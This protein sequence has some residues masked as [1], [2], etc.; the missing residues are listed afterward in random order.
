[1]RRFDNLR[2]G[3]KLAFLVFVVIA[4][5]AGAGT[6]V[7][8]VMRGELLD[9]RLQQ[10]RAITE[11]TRGIA[12]GLQR[13]EAAG[14]L[15]HDEALRLFAVNA[16]SMTYGSQGYVFAYMMDGTAVA[17]PDVSQLGTNRLD[18]LI[19]GRPVIH[20]I[21]DAVLARGEAVIWYDFP[22][23]GGGSAIPKV[24]VATAFAPWGIFFGTGAYV[25]DL[26][27]QFW[28][29]VKL[30]AAGLGVFLI[31]V[32][33]IAWLI[34]KRITSP[35]ARLTSR[36][37]QLSRG[38]LEIDITDA[39]R[40]DE[41]GKMA[42]AMLLFRESALRSRALEREQAD[43]NARRA[44]EDD[45]VRQQ[46]EAAAA[47]AA[48]RLVVGSIGKGLEALSAGDL[49]FRLAEAL[50]GDYEKLRTDYNATMA[51]LTEVMQ[52]L[53]GV[54]S[55][56][57]TS[58][59]EV[60]QG[61]DDLCRRTENHASSFEETAAALDQLTATVRKTV[62]GSMHVSLVVSKTKADAALSGKVVE[63]A[64]QA[65]GGIDNSS[66]QIAQ[67][68][69]VV[70]EIAFQT[71]LLALNAGV[72]AARA[73]E[74]GRGFAVVATEVRAL[75]QRS[76][77]AAKEIK[78]LVSSSVSQVGEGVKLVAET[79]TALSCILSQ[80]TDITTT[81]TEMAASAREQ[82]SG[83]NQVNT[84]VNHMDQV[85]QQN[86]AMV[87]ESTAASHALSRETAE[88]FR[89]TNQFRVGTNPAVAVRASDAPAG[90]GQPRAR[91]PQSAAA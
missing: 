26:D 44:E 53:Q 38:N 79:G 83:L 5:V 34:T 58:S 59:T 71:N 22:R 75:A 39:G 80:V 35:L 43:A 37:Q 3:A 45:R 24:S 88:L 61:A 69:G 76:A 20:E 33:A 14:R 90:E 36:M 84:A 31:I 16:R 78:A 57:A 89:L 70:D 18:V 68:I 73:G 64:M 23:P 82:A 4:C 12:T 51:K 47:A 19:G 17:L 40:T 48:A 41:I 55:F 49:S 29:E 62:E 9:T 32:S 13:D 28:T 42:A 2:L 72:E 63:R 46:A 85:T 6:A 15:T 81:V 21:R 86:A 1:M 30:L 91:R 8:Y 56:I 87:E 66:R 60:A 27:A 10:L 7:A 77:K 11:T 50:P 52:G 74:S 65:M 67:I 25:D 54:A